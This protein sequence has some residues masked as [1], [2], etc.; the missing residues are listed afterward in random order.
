MPP[1]ATPPPHP[2]QL[3]PCTT[4]PHHYPS[5]H[6][7]RP[8]KAPSK[9]FDDGASHS[10][11]GAARPL[12]GH[13]THHGTAPHHHRH[14]TSGPH[15]SSLHPT[16]VV[17]AGWHRAPS[18]EGLADKP[19]DSPA[20]ARQRQRQSMGDWP[21]RGTRDDRVASGRSWLSSWQEWEGLLGHEVEVQCPQRGPKEGR[22]PR[23]PPPRSPLPITQGTT[24]QP[25]SMPS[26]RPEGCAPSWSTRPPEVPPSAP[27][28]KRAQLASKAH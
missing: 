25:C 16:L 10:H 27:T 21:Q 3:G 26:P 13:H 4:R 1:E 7:P 28:P 9:P 17:G 15:G 6:M 23:G 20:V 11:S 24:T 8:R 12:L 5:T 18:G 2:C 19:P 14:C 22:I